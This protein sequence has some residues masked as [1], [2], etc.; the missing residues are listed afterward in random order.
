MHLAFA[1]DLMLMARGDPMS[2]N[3]IM[4]C[5]ADFGAKS[6]LAVNSMKSSLYTAVI[7]GQDLQDIHG[8][9]NFHKDSFPW[10]LSS[11]VLITML[12]SLIKLRLILM[13]GRTLPSPEVSDRI[14]QL[15]RAFLW[16]S[17]HSLIAWKDVCLPKSEG[18][19]GFKDIGC[20]NSALSAKVI[21][22]IQHKKD[23]LWVCWISH[24]YL[25]GSS[26]WEWLPKKDDYPLL[27]RI[28]AIRDSLCHSRVI[29]QRLFR[30]FQAG[31]KGAASIC[32][33]HIISSGLKAL[34][35]SGPQM[36][37]ILVLPPTTPLSFG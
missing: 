19:L 17:K 24:E 37:G 10:P 32:P 22:N 26:F 7:L 36:F 15:C 12:R 3:I 31:S 25:K 13:V 33:K 4:E 30:D 34:K 16:N 23:S 1:D 29:F 27:K 9:V 35:R 18:G 8:L 14:T 5:L 20:W 21:W 11:L 28:L 6:G 2:I